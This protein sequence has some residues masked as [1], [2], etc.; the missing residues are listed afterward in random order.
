[1]SADPEQTHQNGGL[2]EIA[3]QADR[4]GLPTIG[5]I[6]PRNGIARLTPGGAPI[7]GNLDLKKVWMGTD[8]YVSGVNSGSLNVNPLLWGVGLGWRF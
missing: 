1:M 4:M 7:R 8:V 2:T 3:I 6:E 5:P